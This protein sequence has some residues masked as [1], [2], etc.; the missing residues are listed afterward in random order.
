MHSSNEELTPTTAG[1]IAT[2][3][4]IFTPSSTQVCLFVCFE[5]RF[6]YIISIQFC[7]LAQSFSIQQNINCKFCL[8]TKNN[9]CLRSNLVEK[10]SIRHVWIDK[11]MVPP[12][13]LLGHCIRV[14]DFPLFYVC[15]RIRKKYGGG[16]NVFILIFTP[17]FFVV[18]GKVFFRRCFCL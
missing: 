10:A 4:N 3:S 9:C 8:I 13:F 5:L 7:Y 6:C 2:P 15:L 12:S 18:D 14:E 16:N 17:C 11:I 1:I